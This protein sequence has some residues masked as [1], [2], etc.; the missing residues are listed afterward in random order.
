M[1]VLVDVHGCALFG[2]GS[3]G[4]GRA[5]RIGAGDHDDLVARQA[6]VAGEDIRRQVGTGDVADVDFGIGIRPGD[7][8][9]DV[10][11]HGTLPRSGFVSCPVNAG[12]T[13]KGCPG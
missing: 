4:H 1:E 5:V 11:G 3:H 6:L 8:D 10:L 7:G 2:V 13:K 9:Q 12:K